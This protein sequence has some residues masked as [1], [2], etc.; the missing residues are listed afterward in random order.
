M[1]FGKGPERKQLCRSAPDTERA[2]K[3]IKRLMLL[4][5]TMDK[6]PAPRTCEDWI[7]SCR[8]IL[9]SVRDCRS[10]LSPV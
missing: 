7:D 1:R 5:E 6:M 10:E 3:K 4:A 2:L 9:A 8:E